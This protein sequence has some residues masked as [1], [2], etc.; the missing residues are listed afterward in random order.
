MPFLKLL[1][2]KK[3]DK[4]A[5]IALWFGTMPNFKHNKSLLT[6]RLNLKKNIKLNFVPICFQ[7]NEVK[8]KLKVM[9]RL[10]FS[11]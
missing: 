3:K 4:Q 9:Q 8:L 11:P 2:K 1:K 10:W 7:G 5:L 6:I